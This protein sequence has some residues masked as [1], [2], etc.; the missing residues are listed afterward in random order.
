MNVSIRPWQLNDA[1]ALALL[2]NDVRI[3]N[4]VRDYFPHPYALTD[5]QT[6]IAM[7]INK[8]PLL[9]FAIEADGQLAGGIGLILHDDVYRL[10]A[11]TGYWV[12]APFTGKGVASK[13][14]QLITAYAFSN[15]NIIKLH[16]RVFSFNTASMRVLANCGFTEEAVHKNAVIKNGKIYDEHW[17]V[18]WKQEAP[19]NNNAMP[20]PAA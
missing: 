5:A 11:E 10:N 20:E 8:E 1:P 4:H 16:A 13:A 15:F 19:G 12:G 18:I 3:W 2:A 9:N 6:F 17:W 7:N 14:L